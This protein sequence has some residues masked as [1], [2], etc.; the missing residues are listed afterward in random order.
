MARSA[1]LLLLVLAFL[2]DVNCQSSGASTTPDQQQN[3]QN[4]IL[5]TQTSLLQA[6]ME[7]QNIQNQVLTNVVGLLQKHDEQMDNMNE[8]MD[9]MNKQ[10]DNMNQQLN[11]T[12]EQKIVQ[13]HIYQWC[14][15][16]G[17]ARPATGEAR[18]A[19]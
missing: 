19:T 13:N 3:A 14:P 16:D 12:A 15:V 1:I 6:M 8:Q 18:R 2:S 7:Q 9:N 11:N 10:M 4:Q 5:T 17:E